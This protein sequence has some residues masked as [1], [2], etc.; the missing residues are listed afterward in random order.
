[1]LQ[2]ITMRDNIVHKQIA[3]QRSES[4]SS[5]LQSENSNFPPGEICLN[6]SFAFLKVSNF[7]KVTDSYTYSELKRHSLI[8]NKA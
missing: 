5:D 7:N 8:E 6:S 4:E 1:M 2:F 3:K